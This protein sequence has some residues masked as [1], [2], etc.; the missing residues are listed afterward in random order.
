MQFVRADIKPGG[1]T[2]WFMSGPGIDRMYGRMEYLKI[3]GF[4]YEMRRFEATYLM[5]VFESN[6]IAVSKQEKTLFSHIVIDSNSLASG[7]NKK[8]CCLLSLAFA[9]TV[10]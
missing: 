7:S 5:D 2:F 3:E 8:F 10:L 6:V 4:V 1:S 9:A